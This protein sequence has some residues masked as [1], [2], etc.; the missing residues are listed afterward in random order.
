RE[1]S[2]QDVPVA[3]TATTG[4][5]LADRSAVDIRDLAQFTPGLTVQGAARSSGGGSNASVFI[6]GVGQ[7]EFLITFD[8]GVGVYV[9]GVYLGRSVGSILEIA[10]LERVEV[11]RGPQGTL[12]GRNTIGGAI[13]LASKKPQLG[14]VEGFASIGAR[15]DNGFEASGAVNL[16]L[17]DY[18][19][20]RL[21]GQTRTQDG[22]AVNQVTGNDLSAIDRQVVRG[23][24]LFEPTDRFSA[25]FTADASFLD[26]PGIQSSLIALDQ[27]SAFLALYNGFR[28]PSP[29]EPAIGSGDVSRDAD[30]A[31]LDQDGRNE[32]ETWGVAGTLS[33]KLTDDLTLKSISSHRDLD[34]AF[35]ADLDGTSEP[36]VNTLYDTQQEQFSQELQLVGS[37][38]DGRVSFVAGGFYFSEDASETGG[39]DIFAGLY[40]ILEGLPGPVFPAFPGVDCTMTPEFC[41]GGMLNPVNSGFDLEFR[42]D[43]DVSVESY[44]LF[45]QFDIDV[46][47]R[48]GLTIGLRQ[49]WDEKTLDYAVNRAGGSAQLCTAFPPAV[50]GSLGCIGEQIFAVPPSSFE[51]TFNAFTPKFGLDFAV[52]NDVLL[53]ASASRGFKSGGFNGRATTTADLTVFEPETLWTYEAGLKSTVLNGRARINTAVFYSDYENIQ[54]AIA[55]PNPTGPGT[56]SPVINAG[57]AEIYGLEIESLFKI[58]SDLSASFGAAFTHAEYAED[59]T[60]LGQPTGIEEGNDLPKT[61]GTQLF[62]SLDYSRPIMSGSYLLNARLDGSYRS[63]FENEP[64]NFAPVSQDGFGLVNARVGIDT[65]SDTFGISAWIKN[66]GDERYLENAFR[67]G[68][69]TNVGYFTRGREYGITATY[70]F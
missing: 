30:I 17:G 22:F 66:I 51:D 39:I 29:T 3:V 52:T 18:A 26:E 36:F 40:N 68:G 12:F 33:Y 4:D 55:V 9:D 31:N 21:T 27:D 1:Q 70:R 41:G 24:L 69:G 50:A 5:E 59:V 11:L 14:T 15:S 38:A 60:F 44:A 37:F 10:D 42:T 46:T 13:Q 19:A 43:S 25:L 7:D 32:N 61:P 64:S 45:G 53:Y 58:S 62:G 67:S 48:L 2:L 16:P 49:S 35:T 57:S 8:P 23:Q 6:R 54:F 28:S 20:L 56:L 47:D 65:A 63:A 34:A